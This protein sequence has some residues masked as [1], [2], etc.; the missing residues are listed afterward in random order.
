[1]QFRLK[2]LASFNN[3]FIS[4]LVKPFKLVETDT[5]HFPRDFQRDIF[6]PPDLRNPHNSQQ[7]GSQQRLL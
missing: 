6:Y 7:S 2:I 3:S 1:M 5:E 4:V